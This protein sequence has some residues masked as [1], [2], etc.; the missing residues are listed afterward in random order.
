MTVTVEQCADL[1]E[2][3]KVAMQ[4]L[5]AFRDRHL[6]IEGF[7]FDET[8]DPLLLAAAEA[9]DRAFDELDAVT[10]I[11]DNPDDYLDTT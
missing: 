11:L 4:P 10:R 1:L 5:I 7:A 8:D 2:G 9:L 3:I 6:E